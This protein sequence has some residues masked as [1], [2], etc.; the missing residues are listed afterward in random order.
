MSDRLFATPWTVERQAP[1]SSAIS[2]RLLKFMSFE[3]VMLLNHLVLCH[4]LLHLPFLSQHQ[5]LLW[6][7]NSSHQVAKMLELQQQSFQ[8]NI[9]CWF[10]LDLTGLIS[11][12]SKGLSV[13]F[14]STTILK[15]PCFNSLPSLWSNSQMPTWLLERNHSFD[16]TNICWQSDLSTF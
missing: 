16:Y 4:S 1:L 8:V 10:P 3:S 7:V 15:Y 5:S 11:L 9:Q 2:Q 6:W 14:S 12:Q 13:V